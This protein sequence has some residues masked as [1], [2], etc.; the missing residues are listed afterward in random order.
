MSVFYEGLLNM[1]FLLWNLQ[2]RRGIPDTET[3]DFIC[4]LPVITTAQ[5]V[6]S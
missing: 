3:H 2:N 1:I 4:A 6:L 5:V